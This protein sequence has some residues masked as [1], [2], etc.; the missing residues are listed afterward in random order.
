MIQPEEMAGLMADIHIAESVVDMNHNVY[1]TDSSRKAV[2]QAVLE[3]HGVSQTQLDTSFMWYGAHLDKYME[4][5]D[6]AEE[7]LQERL[8]A[9][10]ALQASQA[11]LSVSGDS[12]DVWSSSHRYMFTP[13][14]TSNSIAFHYKA[15]ENWQPGDA[16]TWRAKFMN[17]PGQAMWTIVVSYNDGATEV[18]N[19]RFSGEGWQ[20]TTFHTDS[21]RTAKEIYGLLRLDMKDN[22][23]YIDSMSMVRKR[24]DINRY[25]QRYRQRLYDLNR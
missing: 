18:L 24:L 5:Y 16:Y 12:V 14:A 13:R 10:D 2:K 11:S 8:D 7:M 25:S 4:V 15:D 19:T 23:L 6:R 22:N 3:R 21:T 17:S 9:N 20:E 1:V